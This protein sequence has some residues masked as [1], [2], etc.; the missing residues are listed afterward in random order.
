MRALV[1][2]AGALKASKKRSA[3]GY[4]K[5][6]LVVNGVTVGQSLD[7]PV[8]AANDRRV[9]FTPIL[10]NEEGGALRRS[11]ISTCSWIDIPPN[12]EEFLFAL[13]W[14]PEDPKDPLTQLAETLTDWRDDQDESTS[15]QLD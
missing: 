7:Y 9:T 11:P 3:F 14:E 5:A 2:L 4:V 12:Q 1:N 6:G 15:P 8:A 10:V 13:N